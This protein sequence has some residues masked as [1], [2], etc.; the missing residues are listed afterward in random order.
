[1]KRELTTI[2]TAIALVAA[3]TEGLFAQRRGWMNRRTV[4]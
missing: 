1:M 3:S 4:F 2:I